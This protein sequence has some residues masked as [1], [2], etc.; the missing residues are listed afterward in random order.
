MRRS[1][2]RTATA[3]RCSCPRS[4]TVEDSVQTVRSLGLA[5]GR[6]RRLAGHL[7]AARRQHHHHGGWDQGGAAAAAR[8]HRSHHR[9]EHRSRP[10]P[11][12]SRLGGGHRADLAHLGGAGGAR[13]VRVPQ[14]IS[15]DLDTAHRGA[16]VHHRHL[17]RHV[18]V[19][20]QHRQ[21]LAHGAHHLHRLRGRRCDRR[22]RE[23][24]PLPG[25]GHGCARRPR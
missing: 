24:H 25:D 22:A 17:G 9:H 6:S 21:P 8:E 18:P 20:L 5:N 23:H 4:R 16:R 15:R 2:S 14:G 3:S 12:H 7:P 11:D 19:R 10:N 1:S 13:R